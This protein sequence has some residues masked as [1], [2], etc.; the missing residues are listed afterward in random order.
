[1]S[2]AVASHGT[3]FKV[4]IS[5]TLTALAETKSIGRVG[6]SLNLIDVTNH[7]SAG[8]R[9]YLG[10]LKDGDE[11]A[12]S[13]NYVKNDPGQ[14]YC[15]DNQG[16]VESFEVEFPNGDKAAFSGV[17]RSYGVGEFPEEGSIP[18]D[19]IVKISGAITWTEAP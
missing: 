9:E 14:E 11:I 4:D 18:F 3:Q 15:R 8:A 19:T 6:S 13:G 2:N 7:D 16:T 5:A 12:V 17:V 1:M 10:G